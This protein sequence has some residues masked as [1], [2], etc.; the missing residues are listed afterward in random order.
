MTA[1]LRTVIACSALL[2]LNLGSAAGQI[3]ARATFVGDG[4][5]DLPP[6]G[7]TSPKN[8]IAIAVAPDGTLHIVDQEG[9][10][11]V[12][13]RSGTPVR[14]YGVGSLDEPVAIAFDELGRSYVLDKRLKQVLV[15]DGTGEQQFVIAGADRGASR[16]TDPVGVA[17]GPN[18]FVYVL[19]KGD[20]S[21]GVFSRDGAFV[22]QVGLGE[23]IRDPTGIA[24]GGD[25]RIFVTDKAR[26]AQVVTLPAFSDVPWQGASEPGLLSLGEVEEAAAIA[27]D[28]SGTVVVL[29]GRQ[30]RIWGGSRLDPAATTQTRALYGGVGRGRGSF[31]RPVGLAFTPE[32]HVVVLDRD[33]RKVERIELTEGGDMPRL[34]WDY[35]VRVSQLPPDH[36]GAVTAVWTSTDG[37]ARFV[38]AGPRGRALRVEYAT[39]ERYEDLIGN[40]FESY[41]IP[42]TGGPETLFMGFSR[43][44]GTMALDGS[45][46]LVTEP[47]EDRIAVFDARDGASLGTFGRDYDDDRRLNKPVGIALFSDRSLVVADRDNHRVAVFS[48]DL[49][50][51]LA[52]FPLPEAW[53][54]ALSPD[55]GLFAWSEDGLT[56]LRIPLPDGPPQEIVSGLL[57]GPV[58]DIKFDSRGNMFV[59]EQE[60]S[61]VTVVDSSLERVLVRFGGRDARF[62]ATH[63]SVDALGNVYLANLEEGRTLVYR[64]DAW[65]PDLQ[66][67]RVV[68]SA[69]G[70]AFSWDAVASD[71]LWGYTVSGATSRQ[72]PF[73]PLATTTG[74]SFDLA[75]DGDFE[76][77]WLRVDPVSIAG[78]VSSSAQPIPV[79]HMVAREAAARDAYAEVLDVVTMAESLGARGVLSLASDIAQEVQWHGFSTEFQLGRYAEAVAREEALEGWEGEDRGFELHRRLAIAHESLD[80]FS[81]ALASA[82]R[83]LEV[84]PAR[85]RS[86]EGGLEVLQLGLAAAFEAGV[87]E[88]VV[89]FGDELQGR[90][91]PDRE[92]QFFARLA[93]GHLA[94]DNPRRA[95]QIASVVLDADRAGRIV[96]YDEDRPDLYWVAFQASLAIVDTELIELWAQEYGPYVTGDRR[97][98]YYEAVAHFRAA[99]GE[100]VQAL[101]NFLEVLETD[102]E[103]EFYTDSATVALTLAI[104]RA[105]QDSDTEGHSAGLTFLADY[106][107]DL[108]REVE[109][110]RLAYQD[111]IALFIPR[112]ETLA[113]LGEGFQYWLDGNFAGLIRFFEQTLELDGLTPEQETISRALL[114]GSY[115]GAG[116]AEDAESIYRGILD[117][118]P[119][120]QIEALIERVEA[121]YGVSLFSG[122]VEV[123]RNVRRIR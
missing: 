8:P 35:P 15:Y 3:A 107:T 103:P 93:A 47:N 87:F 90:I 77:R 49:T 101:A 28:G 25:G 14:S 16:L 78:S 123:F 43:T 33:L 83:A 89:S 69:D 10:V 7:S 113:K 52:S 46:L 22:R 115:Q 81:A 111:S 98:P 74:R 21:V 51:I 94:L 95:L 13:D 79:A 41:V 114:A 68:L 72:G 24:V 60:T 71:Y 76:Y 58:Q 112:E 80:Q 99:Q 55:G 108:P 63:L 70:A 6:A 73:T 116:R 66:T 38:M 26:G 45:V 29:D 31:R 118:D 117:L 30:G 20:R 4:S 11:M 48:S 75:L 9:A 44:P 23:L 37:T 84:I 91:E 96:A 40:V 86:T 61:R 97:R 109:D 65:L 121:L 102:P 53:G 85:D 105:L 27:V 39:S 106:A 1:A 34:E 5:F 59:L 64:W 18:G 50:S 57:T 110:L 119:L 100:G 122:Q 56:V 32:R 36:V 88:D 104:F 120:F 17:L 19:D 82:R 92:F 2:F 62:D 67:L 54:V 42:E 12:F